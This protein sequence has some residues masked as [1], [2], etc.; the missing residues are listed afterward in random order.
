MQSLLDDYYFKCLARV[1]GVIHDYWPNAIATDWDMATASVGTHGWTQPG[2][3]APLGA[4]ATGHHNGDTLYGQINANRW[5]PSTFSTEAILSTPSS[6]WETLS[7]TDKKR[8]S[9]ERLVSSVDKI[10]AVH[11]AS[12]KPFHPW[13]SHIGGSG[14]GVPPFWGTGWSE[15]AL[16]AGMASDFPLGLYNSNISAENIGV[17]LDC[18]REIEAVCRYRPGPLEPHAV[19]PSLLSAKFCYVRRWF[20]DRW[21]WRFVPRFTEGS[22]APDVDDSGGNVAFIFDGGPTITIARASL[23]EV[24]APV[25]TMGYWIEEYP[26]IIPVDGAEEAFYCE[27]IASHVGDFAVNPRIG[28]DH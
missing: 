4:K 2:A 28:V 13:L 14:T 23:V 18:M 26:E 1:V 22:V 11:S 3:H 20:G 19:Y 15:L 12:T 6:A 21:V 17:F 5:N 27:R 7:D 16:L 10:N 8:Q 25:S 24:D 9:W